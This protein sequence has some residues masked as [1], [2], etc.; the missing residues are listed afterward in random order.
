[1]SLFHL[2]GIEAACFPNDLLY[3]RNL[4]L[5]YLNGIS[6]STAAGLANLA[7]MFESLSKPRS[8]EIGVA[9][10]MMPDANVAKTK[11]TV[12]ANEEVIFLSNPNC[13]ANYT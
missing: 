3:P 9:I 10:G 1:M 2:T 5:V 4:K 7:K 12:V 6:E 13:L 11:Q 8:T